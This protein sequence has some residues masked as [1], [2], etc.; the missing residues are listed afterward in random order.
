MHA[1]FPATTINLRGSRILTG[2]HCKATETFLAGVTPTDT[3]SY[4]AA[5]EIFAYFKAVATKYELYRYIKLQHKVVEAI[6]DEESCRWNIK[7]EDLA[8]GVISNDWC[9]FL[10]N[11]SGILK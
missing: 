1:T 8:N 11:G 10:I 9:D 4:S 6:W 3:P 5:P 2:A 7:V